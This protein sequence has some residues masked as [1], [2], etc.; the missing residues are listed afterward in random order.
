MFSVKA[1]IGLM[2]PTQVVARGQ[3]CSGTRREGFSPRGPF[4]FGPWEDALFCPCEDVLVPCRGN[5][6]PLQGDA[7]AE[8]TAHA[9]LSSLRPLPGATKVGGAPQ[10]ACAVGTPSLAGWTWPLK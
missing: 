6:E 2:V 7:V 10:G 4:G 8:G 3:G 1:K 5:G 9:G